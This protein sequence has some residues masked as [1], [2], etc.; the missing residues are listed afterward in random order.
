MTCLLTVNKS[1]DFSIIVLPFYLRVL[2][3]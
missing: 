3:P 1:I 2:Q